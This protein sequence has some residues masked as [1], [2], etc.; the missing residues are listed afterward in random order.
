MAGY[1]G[2]QISA[3]RVNAVHLQTGGKKMALGDV[4][5]A[6][7]AGNEALAD[8]LK[9][10]AARFAEPGAEWTVGLPIAEFSFRHLSFPFKGRGQIADA[11][12]FELEAALPFSAEEMTTSFAIMGTEKGETAVLAC[13]IRKERLAHYRALLQKAGIRA[14][15]IAPE[16][17]AL[18]YFYR[19][20]ILPALRPEPASALIVS[21]EGNMLH[22]CA[23]TAAGYLDFHAADGNEKEINRFA[24]SLPAEPE[25]HFTGGAQAALLERAP[26]QDLW[27]RQIGSV[28]D[29]GAPEQL[30]IPIGLA[31]LATAAGDELSFAGDAAPRMKF[32]R[33]WRI[34]A[35]GGAAALVLLVGFL[36]FRNYMKERTFAMINEQTKKVFAAAIPGAKAVKPVFQMEQQLKKL[37]GKMRRAGLGGGGR[38]D[39]IWVLKRMSETLPEGLAMEMDEILYEEGSVTIAGRTDRLESVTRIKELFSITSPFKGAEMLE[40]KASPDGKKVT[41][42]LRMP[43]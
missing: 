37:E 21:A 30:M 6:D 22:L 32:S 10:C 26:G 5:A 3:G 31:A 13:A 12:G 39:L 35:A 9:E 4:Y 18:L 19:G 23:V 38:S 27:K 16:T 8:A 20:I 1:I 43:L 29:G 28:I 34:A 24:A 11:I 40:S 15:R 36:G 33:D 41:F 14:R 17:T 42:K 2:L 25:K 7:Y